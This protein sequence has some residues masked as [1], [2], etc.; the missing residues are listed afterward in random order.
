MPNHTVLQSLMALMVMGGVPAPSAAAGRD[1]DTRAIRTH[2]DSIFDAYRRGDRP[3]VRVTHAQ[4]WLGFIRTSDGV[5]RGLDHYMRDADR[6]LQSEVALREWEILDFDVRFHG[7][8][9]LVAYVARILSTH[10]ERRIEARIRALDVYLKRHG[11]WEQVAS[12]VSTHPDAVM[13][14]AAE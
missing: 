3:T 11:E 5:V 8:V 7:D 1:V 9:G 13:G 2:I 10:G 6:I 14:P 4:D 12:N